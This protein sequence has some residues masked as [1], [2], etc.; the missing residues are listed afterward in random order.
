MQPFNNTSV[1]SRLVKRAEE[2]LRKITP[3]QLVGLAR[4]GSSAA[5]QQQQQQQQQQ[6]SGQTQA[7]KQPVGVG[8]AEP[9]ASAP[10]ALAEGRA[11]AA[12]PAA[13]PTVAGESAEAAASC[14]ASVDARGVGDSRISRAAECLTQHQPQRACQEQGQPQQPQQCTQRASA[15]D[16]G[17]GCAVAGTNAS[18][19]EAATGPAAGEGQAGGSDSLP[20]ALG[21]DD[22]SAAAAAAAAGGAMTH[23]ALRALEMWKTLQATASTPSTVVPSTST[24]PQPPDV[25]AAKHN[26]V[27][28]N[29]CPAGAPVLQVGHCLCACVRL[30]FG[31]RV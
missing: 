11:A 7:W 16:A 22:G 27:G 2:Q 3:P 13:A 24:S 4:R 6:G 14:Q 20:G 29:T 1:M 30:L 12:G 5:Q 15:Q 26:S 17:G 25:A 21:N 8:V 18:P 19:V 23:H 28:S 10:T 31:G 9:V